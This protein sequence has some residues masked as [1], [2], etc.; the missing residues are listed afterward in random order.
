MSLLANQR[1][2][3]ATEIV[4]ASA[5]LFRANAVPL[6]TIAAIVI[7]PPAIAALFLPPELERVLSF[8]ENILLGIG[9]G[10]ATLYILALMT[11]G[12]ITVREAFHRVPVGKVIAAQILFGLAV[13]AGAI[14]LIIPAFIFAVRYSLATTVAAAE[15][16]ASGASLKRSWTLTKGH[17]WHAFGTMLLGFGVVLIVVVGASVVLGIVAGGLDDAMRD[18]FVNF[19]MAVVTPFAWAVATMLYIDLRVRVDGADVEAMIAEL[20]RSNSG[21]PVS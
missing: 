17:F 1:A 3:S 7:I 19:I 4:D 20:P 10:A 8:V 21:I 11:E 18:L 16:T 13:I 2:R 5:Q 12:E 6:M 15:R 14:L 9:G